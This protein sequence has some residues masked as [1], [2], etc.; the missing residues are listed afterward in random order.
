MST[1]GQFCPVALASEIFAERWT[2]LVIRELMCGSRRF[3]Q[4]E[5]GVPRMSKPLL[6][7][8]LRMLERAGVV[9]RSQDTKWPEYRLTAAGE[10][11]GRLVI[12]LGEWGQRWFRGD[13]ADDE[14]DPDLLMWDIHRRINEDRLP[15]G[16]TVVQFDLTGSH[17]KSYWLLL[18]AN[19]VTVC[20]EDPDFPIDLLVTADT[21]ALHEIWLG[22]R[23]LLDA[24]RN[25]LVVLDG[26]IELVRA[27][28][29]WL[30]LSVFATIAPAAVSTAT[31][32]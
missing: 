31:M 5:R 30:A 8:R 6:V 7:Q 14:L 25:D 13:I 26:P 27:F 23:A 19:D 4:L 20:W 21:V 3:S 10:E 11:L 18:E 9:Y 28:P 16:R 15:P 17:R 32:A 24:M 1:Y 12:E 22:R 29:S 2:P